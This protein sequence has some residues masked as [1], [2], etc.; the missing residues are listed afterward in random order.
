[1]ATMAGAMVVSAV[2]MVQA[3]LDVYDVND[4][5]EPPAYTVGYLVMRMWGVFK[6]LYVKS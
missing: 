2:T 6:D 1:M 4:E 5:G 3:M